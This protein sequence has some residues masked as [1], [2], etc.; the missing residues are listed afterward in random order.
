MEEIEGAR[1]A[2]FE[3]PSVGNIGRIPSRGSS[4]G[5]VRSSRGAGSLRGS[6]KSSSAYSE[7]SS[8]IAKYDN[9]SESTVEFESPDTIQGEQETLYE[10]ETPGE[11]PRGGPDSDLRVSENAPITRN[12]QRAFTR[13]GGSAETLQR[14]VSRAYRA[15]RRRGYTR[16][17]I[18]NKIKGV[19]KIIWGVGIGLS[20]AEIV[21][22]VWN[23]F[24]DDQET[25]NAI[26]GDTT[27][28]PPTA[29][30]KKNNSQQKPPPA[31]EPPKITKGSITRGRQ[32][33]VRG[34]KQRRTGQ[35]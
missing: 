22:L 6:T 30:G 2:R 32:H 20:V 33:N 18:R 25:S 19:D 29:P 10:F 12:L 1:A 26:K 21:N 7:G 11:E 3:S 23:A 34:V 28:I 31:P 16:D 13:A 35:P 24:K 27:D 9:R 5:S 8:N 4:V 15:A 14:T 17:E